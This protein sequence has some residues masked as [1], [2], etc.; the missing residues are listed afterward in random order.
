MDEIRAF[1]ESQGLELVEKRGALKL[2]RTVAERKAFLSRKKL[3][4]VGSLK[5]DEASRRMAYTEMLVESGSG[6]SSGMDMDGGMSSGFGFKTETYRT[7]AGP[8][9]G[10]IVEQ[11]DF[12]GRKYEYRF[13][14]RGV[15][16][17][18]EAIAGQNGFEFRYEI[19]AGAW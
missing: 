7:G 19:V 8:R 6:M 18:L 1:A 11:S 17:G 5:I 13:D 12:F 16:A 10:T 2:R 9:E 15:R 3:D 14:F 4:Y